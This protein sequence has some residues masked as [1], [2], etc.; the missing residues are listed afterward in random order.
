MS[1]KVDKSFVFGG[2][3][4]VLS[5]LGYRRVNQYAFLPQRFVILTE[6]ARK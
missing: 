2:F 1:A 6:I 3:C 4:K 5:H